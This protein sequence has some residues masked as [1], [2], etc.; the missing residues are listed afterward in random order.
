MR[1][2]KVMTAAEEGGGLMLLKGEKRI[3]GSAAAD[4]QSKVSA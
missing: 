3:T 4:P 2:N 1:A